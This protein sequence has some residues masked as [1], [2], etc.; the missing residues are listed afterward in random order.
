[1]TSACRRQGRP[2][3]RSGGSW[4]DRSRAWPVSA[5]TTPKPRV[6]GASGYRVQLGQGRLQEGGLDGASFGFSLGH[7][8]RRRFRHHHRFRHC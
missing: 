2:P 3:A 1:M 5:R 6:Q 8:C 7:L 4:R